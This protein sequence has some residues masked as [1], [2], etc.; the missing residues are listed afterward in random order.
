M[1][2]EQAVSAEQAKQNRNVYIQNAMARIAEMAKTRR[3][4]SLE[5]IAS[6]AQN[7]PTQL[8][9]LL[10]LITKED[11]ISQMTPLHN[12]T[13]SLLCALA[14]LLT[15]GQ[16]NEFALYASQNPNFFEA[17]SNLN[18]ELISKQCYDLVH[19]YFNE[20]IHPEMNPDKMAQLSQ[21]HDALFQ[22]ADSA[23]TFIKLKYD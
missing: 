10:G 9:D 22:F 7:Q 17:L 14:L 15:N 8:S 4:Q 18:F 13:R 1:T 12:G 5:R 20:E 23:Y 16:S 11:Q 2:T 3:Q 6:I 21:L 19:P